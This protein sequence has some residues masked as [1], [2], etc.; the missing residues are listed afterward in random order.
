[1]WCLGVDGRSKRKRSLCPVAWK[2]S[3]TADCNPAQELPSERRKQILPQTK[4]QVY[5]DEANIHKGVLVTLKQIYYKENSFLSGCL[6]KIRRMKQ[7]KTQL[8]FP[9]M[10]LGVSLSPLIAEALCSPPPL[11]SY[12]H[13]IYTPSFENGSFLKIHLDYQ[14][15]KVTSPKLSVWLGG[16]L[17]TAE[18]CTRLDINAGLGCAGR[19]EEPALCSLLQP[20]IFYV[21]L[22]SQQERI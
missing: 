4:A 22:V 15:L 13:I 3:Y 8:Q 1:M 11:N 16:W 18:Q 5:E 20:I 6:K 7:T 10:P 12:L 17:Q 14:T 21:C 2:W 19:R 9:L